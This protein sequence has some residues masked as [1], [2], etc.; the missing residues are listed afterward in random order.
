MTK[1]DFRI[2]LEAAVAGKVEALEAIFEIYS[3]LIDTQSTIDGKVDEDLRQSILIKIA[4]SI[5]KFKI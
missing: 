3:G 5:S 1:D 4:L 2:I